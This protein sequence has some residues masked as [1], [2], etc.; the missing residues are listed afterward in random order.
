MALRCTITQ[1]TVFMKPKGSKNTWYVH[2]VC[3]PINSTEARPE[4]HPEFNFPSNIPHP[5][6]TW[7]LSN[8]LFVVQNDW[9]LPVRIRIFLLCHTHTNT[10]THTFIIYICCLFD[11]AVSNSGCTATK[12]RMAVN[13]RVWVGNEAETCGLKL[14]EVWKN[15][16]KPRISLVCVC[17]LS[18]LGFE[19]GTS[20]TQVGSVTTWCNILDF[21]TVQP[22]Q[23]M[24]NLGAFFKY[25]YGKEWK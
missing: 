11:D 12:E 19:T 9:Q 20:R 21:I 16:V 5:D 8:S 25:P 14:I 24:Q 6:K 7:I 10:R 18:R 3:K 2:F 1:C 17:S 13:E 15:P 23:R 4:I 22:L